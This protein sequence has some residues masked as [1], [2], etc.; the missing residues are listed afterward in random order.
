[1]PEAYPNTEMAYA[2]RQG[3]PFRQNQDY[4]IRCPEVLDDLEE[5][6]TTG[7]T[8]KVKSICTLGL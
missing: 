8:C 7:T 3:R 1:M 4:G 6:S 2:L 5:A